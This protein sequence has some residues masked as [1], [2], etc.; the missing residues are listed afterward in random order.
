MHCVISTMKISGDSPMTMIKNTGYAA[1]LT[2][3]IR[4]RELAVVLI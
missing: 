3:T 4:Y 1:S 2:I